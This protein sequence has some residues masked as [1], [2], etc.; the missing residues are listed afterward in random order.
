[1]FN[2]INNCLKNK[3]QELI[4]KEQELKEKEEKKIIEKAK[5]EKI[6]FFKEC[7]ELLIELINNL[8][9]R[10][11]KA[12]LEFDKKHYD[13]VF[14]Y[15]RQNLHR[16]LEYIQFLKEIYNL[17]ESTEAKEDL[18]EIIKMIEHKRKLEFIYKICT[19]S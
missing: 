7:V 6:I 17:L 3:E 15:T 19:I 10:L 2:Y 18:N 5:K 4:N 1:M 8:R 16:D 13:I 12:N 14:N 9:I 11:H